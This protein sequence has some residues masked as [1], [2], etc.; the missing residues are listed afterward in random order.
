MDG[1]SL[2][3]DLR[4]PQAP[5]HYYLARVRSRRHHSQITHVF[6]PL[7]EHMDGSFSLEQKTSKLWN[8]HSVWTVAKRMMHNNFAQ[9]SLVCMHHKNNG[10]G[11]VLLHRNEATPAWDIWPGKFQRPRPVPNGPPIPG[12][13]GPGPRRRP[14]KKS[15]G[16]KLLSP[17]SHALLPAGIAPPR[18][19]GGARARAVPPP[20]AP[21]PA[22]DPPDEGPPGGGD[23]DDGGSDGDDGDDGSDDDDPD[24]GGDLAAEEVQSTT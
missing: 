4:I 17:L 21:P 6:V 9:V 24:E 16:V 1:W 10:E 2:L 3:F 13:D 7:I 19:V 12:G 23:G 15:A 11:T 22:H 8:F 20:P 18:A 14:A 5:L